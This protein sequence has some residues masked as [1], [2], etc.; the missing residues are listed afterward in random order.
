MGEIRVRLI[1]T[2][3][4]VAACAFAVAACAR[5][6]K[7]SSEPESILKAPGDS[8]QLQLLD[9]S[10]ARPLANADVELWSD[11][12]I[13]CIKAPCPTDGKQWKGSSDAKGRVTIPKSALNT[14][15]NIRSGAYT[16]DLV[17]D[18][19]SDAKGGWSIE[20]LSEDCAELC[21]HPIK[22]LDARTHAPIANKPVLIEIRSATAHDVASVTSNALGYVL[23]PFAIVAKGSESSWVVVEGYRDAKIDF[24]AVRRKL[25]LQP[26]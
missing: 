24:A 12:G 5:A 13:R 18:A 9:A 6:Q 26:L 8:V 7:G 23:V 20:M 2:T 19:T 21:P 17:G 10:T 25:K 15:A 1:R 11:N 4:I 22:L 14:T 16:G 3:A